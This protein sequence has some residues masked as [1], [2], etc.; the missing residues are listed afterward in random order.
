MQQSDAVCPKCGKPTRV[1]H[2]VKDGKK[3]RVANT[4]LRR[5]ILSKERKHGKI[6]RLLQK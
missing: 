1:G 2:V 5:K 3:V 6:E 4:R